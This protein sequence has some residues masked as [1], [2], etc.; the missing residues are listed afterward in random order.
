MITS[1]KTL[2]VIG[3]STVSGDPLI[4]RRNL[5]PIGRQC[6]R[7]ARQDRRWRACAASL[8]HGGKRP[9]RTPS[10]SEYHF[11]LQATR[12]ELTNISRDIVLSYAALEHVCEAVVVGS[13]RKARR[14]LR[15]VESSRA[16]LVYRILHLGRSL[17][18]KFL[19]YPV[20]AWALLVKNEISYHNRRRER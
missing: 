3:A 4:R 6:G 8:R 20:W 14:S 9:R 13:C 16:S 7:T 17:T 2:R 18:V 15:Q 11:E 19:K 5:T 12:T 10:Q 1:L